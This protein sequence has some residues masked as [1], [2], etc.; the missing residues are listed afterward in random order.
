M[1]HLM[2]AFSIAALEVHQ[3][4]ADPAASVSGQ[5]ADDFWIL[6]AALKRFVQ[7]EGN[8]QLPLEASSIAPC[9][10]CGLPCRCSSMAGSLGGRSFFQDGASPV[11]IKASP[12]D[13]HRRAPSQT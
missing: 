9:L 3:L 4:F 5:E 10:S 13:C 1:R 6:V 7:Q 2:H 8:G 12:G 11:S